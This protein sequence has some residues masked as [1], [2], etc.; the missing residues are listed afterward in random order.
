[1]SFN[2]QNKKVVFLFIAL[3]ALSWNSISQSI[4]NDDYKRAVSFLW[5]NINNKKAYNLSVSPNWFDDNSGFWYID[6]GQT[7]KNFVKVAFSD[8]VK[9]PLFDQ[10][11]VADILSKLTKTAIDHLNIELNALKHLHGEVFQ[12]K[13]NNKAY[14]LNIANYTIAEKEFTQI[15]ENQFES[16]SPNGKWIAFTK[17]FNIYLKSVDNE[18]TFQLS[19]DGQ[20]GYEYASYYGWYDK[21]IGENGERPRRFSVNWSKD[22]NYL[23]ANIVDTRKAEKMYL[24]DWSIDSLFKPKLLS[25]YRGSPGDTTMV[26]YIPK[27]FDIQTKKAIQTKLPRN[28]HINAVG[29]RWSNKP[30]IVFATIPERGFQKTSILKIDLITGTTETILTETSATNIDSFETNLIDE[31]GVIIFTSE[32]NGWK[33]LYA[34][35]L[36]SKKIK[37]LTNGQYFVNEIKYID[38]KKGII[39]FMASGK[40]PDANP[41]HQA[42]YKVDLKGNLKLLTPENL[43][44][45]V[46]FSPNKNHFVDNMSSATDPTVT[47]LRSLKNGKILSELTKANIDKLVDENWKAP[48]I[49]EMIGIDGLS[50]IYGALWKPTNFDSLKK[51]PIIDHSYTGPHTQM[52]PK[53]FRR[54]L[55]SS[56]QALAELGFIVMMVDGL[57]TTGRSKAFRNV[58]Y[59]NMGQN[60]KDHKLA[61]EQLALKY[62]WIDANKVGIFGH[63]AGGYDAAH[64]LLE[65]PN[66]YKVGVSS[67]ADHDFRMEKAWW[68]EMYM[69]WPVDEKYHNVSNITMAH[70]LKGKLLLVHGGLDDNVNPSATFKLVEALVKYDKEFDLLIFPSQRHGYRG[71]HATYFLKKRWNYFVE[72]LLEATPIW[73]FKVD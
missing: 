29:L 60:L 57:G 12:F 34:V 42:L 24:L 40:D 66:F 13:L 15:E 17:D 71:I 25:Y 18:T 8:L 6:Q 27:I 23:I 4:S 54:V 37:A 47:V 35:Q 70:K 19:K 20:K 14:E 67:S 33:Q 61:I 38:Q 41:Y 26:H 21:M 36:N 69:G 64:G 59:K 73:D 43:H 56:N 72:H 48:Q 55:A 49:F 1:M 30:N 16:L 45:I 62:P 50:T 53:D 2:I 58:S 63:S 28:T 31:K 3:Y 44:H 65:F 10:K 68:P 11:K 46:A 7:G 39:Y 5:K 51:Y 9:R 22:S 52:F 32:R